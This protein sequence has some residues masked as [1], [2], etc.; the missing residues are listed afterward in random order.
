M[1][2]AIGS[3]RRR[4]QAD[5]YIIL[6]IW[7]KSNTRFIVP[8]SRSRHH[9]RYSQNGWLCRWNDE[10]QMKQYIISWNFELSVNKDCVKVCYFIHQDHDIACISTWWWVVV[11]CPCIVYSTGLG[12]QPCG[13]RGGKRPSWCTSWFPKRKPCGFLGKRP[14]FLVDEEEATPYL[15]YIKVAE[16]PQADPSSICTTTRRHNP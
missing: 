9:I 8:P 7:V 14:R 6:P 10:Y 13:Q 12:V 3:G 16:T 1:C 2:T 11:Q 15:E 4:C 5:I